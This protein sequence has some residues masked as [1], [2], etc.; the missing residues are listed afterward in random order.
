MAAPERFLLSHSLVLV[1]DGVIHYHSAL[2]TLTPVLQ[3][4]QERIGQGLVTA[5]SLSEN[6][7]KPPNVIH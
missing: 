1:Q 6:S 3:T 7:R 5:T 4:Q 2:V